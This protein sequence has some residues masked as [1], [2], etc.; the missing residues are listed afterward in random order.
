MEE[1]KRVRWID[2]SAKQI[3]EVAHLHAKMDFGPASDALTA[4]HLIEA[5]AHRL[6]EL[7][8][9]TKEGEGK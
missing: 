8:Q 6:S 4:L 7:S 9:P 3:G 5:L 2:L 1:K